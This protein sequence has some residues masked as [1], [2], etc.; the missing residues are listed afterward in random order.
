[1]PMATKPDKMVRY[2]KELYSLMSQ[3]PMITSSY[4]VT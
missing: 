1:M 3:D 4:K 2:N